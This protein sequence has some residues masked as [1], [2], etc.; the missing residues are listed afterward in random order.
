[1]P[2]GYISKLLRVLDEYALCDQYP[3]LAQYQ[4]LA[5]M[6]T[7]SESAAKAILIQL[8]EVIEYQKDFPNLLHRPPTEEQLY[9]DGRPDV[10]IG[11]L[12]EGEQLRFGIKFFDRPR[13]ILAAGAT[14]SGKT[15]FFRTLILAVNKLN[16]KQTK[17][18]VQPDNI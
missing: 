3:E 11:E 16:E 15:T 17:Q 7:L 2:G 5:E 10:E 12:T 6:G 8:Q 18:T 1:M 14:G 13:H 9:A 4:M